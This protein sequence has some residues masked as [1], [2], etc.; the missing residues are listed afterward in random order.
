M[1]RWSRLARGGAAAAVLLVVAAPASAQHHDHAA[2][3]TALG[4]PVRFE[5][6][7]RPTVAGV[8]DQGVQM[9]H[10]FAFDDA[11]GSFRLAAHSDIDCTM[12]YWGTAMAHWGR[13]ARTGRGDALADGWRALDT[14]GLLRRPPSPREARYLEALR[15]RYRDRLAAGPRLYAEAMT[16]LAADAP[17]DR[18]AALFAAL[19][20]VEQPAASAADAERLG[21]AAL[22]L[23]KRLPAPDLAV[24]H[25]ATLA[26]D[27]PGLAAAVES[28]AQALAAAAG[29]SSALQVLSA[30]I[31]ARLGQWDAALAAAQRAADTARAQG[32]GGDELRALDVLVYAE[33][34]AGRG[35]AARAVV[36]RLDSGYLAGVDD[37]EAAALRAAIVARV[38][39]D[40]D[41]P[42]ATPASS[43][44]GDGLAALPPLLTR[45]VAAGTK[46]DAS[47]AA[48]AAAQLAALSAALPE[49]AR[50]V[51][52]AAGGWAA[53]AAG[54]SDDAITR[55][56]AAAAAEEAAAG[57]TLPWR[58]PI[59]PAREQLAD[60]L[61]ALGRP[62]EAAA[63]YQAVL[64][65]WPD[66]ARARRGLAETKTGRP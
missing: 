13:F 20:L 6:T 36:R 1:T 44:P 37:R 61:R 62:G 9:L 40:G 52:D 24:V 51:V 27:R 66:R 58:L 22:D 7:C 42:P 60:L 53:L 31:F 50:W 65:R 48:D 33:L 64:A 2:T 26:G 18:H 21:R 4:D 12:A 45:A 11:L 46:R 39:L 19:A 8:I 5:T 16:A 34:Q 49:D 56:R 35:D 14:A 41:D 55:L 43:A 17:D 30:R 10:T 59:L 63:E 28:E 57:L 15:V 25:Y 23:L 29:Q 54:R 3:G 38:A 47:A 32:R